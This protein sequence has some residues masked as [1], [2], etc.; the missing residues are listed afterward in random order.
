MIQSPF[1]SSLALSG[2][3]SDAAMTAPLPGAE[4]ADFGALLAS[5]SAPGAAPAETGQ[6][7]TSLP[8]GPVTDPASAAIPGKILPPALPVAEPVQMPGI[9]TDGVEGPPA[10]AKTL[11][12]PKRGGHPAQPVEV[13]AAKV[14]PVRIET[15][16]S[17]TAETPEADCAHPIGT[18]PELPGSNAEAAPVSVALVAAPAPQPPANGAAT[19][20]KPVP[21]DLPVP[22][23]EQLK[24]KPLAGTE[25]AKPVSD[26]VPPPKA[27]GPVQRT[28]PDLPETASE[29]AQ[30]RNAQHRAEA[31][32]DPAPAVPAALAVKPS[33]PVMRP[34][35][36]AAK[37]LSSEAAAGQA[38]VTESGA[39][40]QP[41]ATVR[42]ELPLPLAA[43]IGRRAAPEVSLALPI[44]AAADNEIKAEVAPGL[45]SGTSALQPA[46]LAAATPA[47]ALRPHDFTALIDRLS[48][49]REAVA[50]QAVSITVSHQEFGPV[51][52]NFRPE[53]AGLNVTVSSAD[54]DFARAAAAAP[55]PVLPVMPSEPGGSALQQ[56]SEGGSAQS[57]PGSEGFAQSRGGSSD[58]REGQGQ[59][60]SSPAQRGTAERQP[61]RRGIFA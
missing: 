14:C 19:S 13:P 59:H 29:Q 46:P 41:V 47:P 40:S 30:L 42:I 39:A 3:P 61:A 32:A 2:V 45:A 57:G 8:D 54:P 49:A 38:P 37:P 1:S 43:P 10:P 15:T 34:L 33:Q 44:A 20:G 11:A 53:D 17:G 28:I 7:G 51:R 60:H 6:P 5:L 58:R 21:A 4:A 24:P 55:A 56:R 52:L 25:P 9:A 50:P 18:A 26:R 27:Q 12:K 48:A 31:P 36:R 35:P 16:T 22:V 23:M